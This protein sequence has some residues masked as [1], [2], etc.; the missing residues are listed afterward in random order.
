MQG[1]VEER[2][3]TRWSD[4]DMARLAPRLSASALV[5]HDRED[6]MVPWRKGASFARA[7]PGA[8]F[9]STEGLGHRRILAD[10]RVTALAA[11]FIAGRSA[12]ASVA[13]PALANPA[14]L[15]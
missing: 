1:A 12:V 9:F 13:A 7:W 5:I 14:P 10:E 15:Y 11:D 4:L 6:R 3:A 8:R 2:F